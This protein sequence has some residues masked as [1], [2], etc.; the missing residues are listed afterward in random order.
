MLYSEPDAGS[1]SREEDLRGTTSRR[2]HVSRM[3]EYRSRIGP[4]GWT[5][6]STKGVDM[7]AYNEATSGGC[8]G[9][10][11]GVYESDERRFS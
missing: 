5:I 1:M 11:D 6:A 9:G 7:S 4:D 2:M 10:S 8:L 3:A